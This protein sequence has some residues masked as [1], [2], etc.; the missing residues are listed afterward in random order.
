MAQPVQTH[1]KSYNRQQ[2]TPIANNS[3]FGYHFSF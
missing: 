1:N 3:R 2:Y